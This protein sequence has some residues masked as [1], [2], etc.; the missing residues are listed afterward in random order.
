M[1]NATAYLAT[2]YYVRK[3]KKQRIYTNIMCVCW[4][5]KRFWLNQVSDSQYFFFDWLQTPNGK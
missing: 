5:K 4:S 3:K 1:L 2:Q